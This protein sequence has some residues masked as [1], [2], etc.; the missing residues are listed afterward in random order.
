MLKIKKIDRENFSWGIFDEEK[1][2]FV[3]VF[4]TKAEAKEYL[5]SKK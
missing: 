1:K 4:E 5:K 3:K 2:E